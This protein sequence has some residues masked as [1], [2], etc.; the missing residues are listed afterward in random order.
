M[1]VVFLLITLLF[2]GPAQAQQ[3][4]KCSS[5]DTCIKEYTRATNKIKADYKKDLAVQRKGREQTLSE[6]FSTRAALAQESLGQ[7]I[8][9]QID[10]LNDCLSKVR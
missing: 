9:P 10:K 7:A 8:G 6:H 3:C 1:R 4:A 2:A 5:A